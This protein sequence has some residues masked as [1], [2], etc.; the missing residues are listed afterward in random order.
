MVHEEKNWKQIVLNE[1]NIGIIKEYINIFGDFLRKIICEICENDREWAD[2]IQ[3]Y[4]RIK[5]DERK[6]SYM[7]FKENVIPSVDEMDLAG[8]IKYF[9]Y[10]DR[11]Q[12]EHMSSTY[13]VTDSFY[14]LLKR[15]GDYRNKYEGHLTPNQ[16][17]EYIVE[18][19]LDDMEG[20][21]PLFQESN[22]KKEVVEVY[23]KKAESLRDAVYDS[24]EFPPVSIEQIADECFASEDEIKKALVDIKIKQH[25]NVVLVKE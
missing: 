4:D 12:E 13:H 19:L 6:F 24:R 15:L 7:L 21:F 3:E 23:E 16:E 11:Y 18:N 20:I 2:K 1:S 25:D 10:Y 17:R 8:V 9:R 5:R 14:E 22:Y